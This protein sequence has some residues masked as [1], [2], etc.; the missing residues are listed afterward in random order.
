MRMQGLC[1][2]ALLAAGFGL[3]GSRTGAKTVYSDAVAAVV[4]DS[5]ITVFDLH[6]ESRLQEK[7]LRDRF[8]G[9]ELRQRVADLREVV[10][11]RLIA[12][13]L[14]YAEFQALGARI[15]PKLLARRIDAF[16]NRETGGD[17][18]KFEVY[19]LDQGSSFAEFEERVSKNLAWELMLQEMVYRQVHVSPT[20]VGAYYAANPGVFRTE[21]GV[22]LRVIVIPGEGSGG[23]TAEGRLKRVLRRLREGEKFTTVGVAESAPAGGDLGWIDEGSANPEF[24]KA[25]ADLDPGAVADPIRVDDAIYLLQLVD[26]RD[27]GMLPLDEERK[28]EITA[29]LRREG[30]SRR[31]A[32]VLARLRKKYHV[33]TFF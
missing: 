14:F 4:G 27:G 29:K 9:E 18:A 22:H 20:A 2:V 23:E 3:A 7:Q 32:E 25:T 12:R 19:L 21:P 30:E 24:L 31:R 11:D 8:K 1:A 6:Q 10:A 16:I 5:V 13:E 28:A 17:R 26:R 15:P 33:K